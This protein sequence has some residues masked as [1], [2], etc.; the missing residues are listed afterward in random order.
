MTLGPLPRHR[1]FRPPRRG[2]LLALAALL[3][4]IALRVW[5]QTQDAARSGDVN[6]ASESATATVQRV[7]DGDTL[8][9]AGGVRVRLLG[10]DTPETKIAGQP[11][12]PWGPQASEFTAQFCRGGTVRLEFD[13]ERF[14][15]YH[16]TL[17]YVYVD[18]VM[19]N[20]ELIRQGFSAAQTQYPFRSDMKRR[21]VE[22][23]KEARAAHRGI[24]SL[25]GSGSPQ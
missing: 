17:A 16:R 9:L 21:F 24:W 2:S 15:R 8:L 18:D 4:W 7:V 20:E 5:Q 22:A 11:P 19:L 1:R 10:V 23:E 3:L 25:P 14:D 13:R 6:T 12:E